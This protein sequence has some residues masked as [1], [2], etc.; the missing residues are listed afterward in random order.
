[1]KKKKNWTAEERLRIVIEALKDETTIESICKKFKVAPSQVHAWKKYF[2][3]N[4]AEI[5]DNKKSIEEIKKIKMEC[6]QLYE[7]IGELTVERDFLKK[8]YQAVQWKNDAT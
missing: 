3:E 8:N 5:F 7:K 1:M 2:T 6:R 4:G